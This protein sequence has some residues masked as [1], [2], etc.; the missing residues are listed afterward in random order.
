MKDIPFFANTPDDTHC[1]QASLKIVLKY[2]FPDKDFTFEEL[3]K[4]TD[5]PLNKWTWPS[6]GLVALKKM[7]LEVKF[8]A[9]M[10]YNKFAERGVDYFYEIYPNDADEMIKNSDIESEI[11]NAKEMIKHNIFSNEKVGLGDVERWFDQN[12]LIVLLINSNVLRNKKGISGH[13]VVL[14]GLDK[15]NVVIHDPGLPPMKNRAISKDLFL[16]A[17]RYPKEDY[18][19]MLFKK[20]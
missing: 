6:A 3:D 9:K 16:K 2:F 4:M 14:I 5:K 10:D 12:Y 11:E 1:F 13:F 20:V 17:W 7:G 15:N 18:D 8:Y 19:T